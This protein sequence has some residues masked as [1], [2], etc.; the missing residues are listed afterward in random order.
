MVRFLSVTYC[1]EKYPLTRTHPP[2]TN[3]PQELITSSVSLIWHP[4]GEGQTPSRR[5]P[6]PVRV[7]AW[8]EQGARLKKTL[9]QPKLMWRPIAALTDCCA[10]PRPILSS[11]LLLSR[12]PRSIDLLSIVR[13]YSPPRT[14][15]RDVHPLAKR[16]RSLVLL[17]HSEEGGAGAAEKRKVSYL[18]EARNEDERDWIAHALNIVVA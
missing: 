4:S 6:S 11:S 8:I 17:C 3:A 7:D 9:V 2:C 10:P 5:L 12:A 13:I 14:V 15:D 16:R 1:P 18:F